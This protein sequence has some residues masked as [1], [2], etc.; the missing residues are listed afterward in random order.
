MIGK[1][2]TAKGKTP[3]KS[4]SPLTAEQ[5]KR[6]MTGP[7]VSGVERTRINRATKLREQLG[8]DY[9]GGDANDTTQLE[10]NAYERAKRELLGSSGLGSGGGGGTSPLDRYTQ[11]IQR[12]LTSGAYRKPQDD[13]MARLSA[14]YAPAESSVNTAMDSL[15]ASL[16]AQQNPYAGFQAAQA[17]VPVQLQDFLAAQGVSSQPVQDFANTLQAQNAGQAAA[18]QNLANMLGGIYG[19]NQAGAIGD[20]N[21]QRADLLNQL[22]QSRL[23]YG[24]QLESQAQKQQQ[25]YLQ[26]LMQAL[27]K[28]GRPKKGALL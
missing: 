14:M 6:F 9:L 25:Q 18:Y 19:A 4:S 15:V 5:Q 17:Q 24:A 11:T 26:M 7:V 1:A 12:L 8:G 27:A 20:V 23:G 28:G 3:V 10:Q 21:V 16:Q 13:L 22:A 2:N